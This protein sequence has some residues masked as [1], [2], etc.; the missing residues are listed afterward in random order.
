[1][2][3]YNR[4]NELYAV[5]L[6]EFDLYGMS[7]LGSITPER[8]IFSSLGLSVQTLERF[9]TFLALNYSIIN[10]VRSVESWETVEAFLNSDVFTPS[11]AH[12]IIDFLSELTFN[13]RLRE[14]ELFERALS[15]MKDYIKIDL[16]DEDRGIALTLHY[17]RKIGQAYVV[18]LGTQKNKTI[19]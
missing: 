7:Y 10:N 13:V 2:A 11:E 17:L 6:K 3:E 8:T 1:M 15:I 5:Y 14:P 12:W 18:E 16:S 19:N 4:N 9:I